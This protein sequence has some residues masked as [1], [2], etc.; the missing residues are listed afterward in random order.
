MDI[1]SSWS[2]PLG[3]QP[4]PFLLDPCVHEQ[5]ARGH[6][7]LPQ[8]RVIRGRTNPALRHE[9]V[10]RLYPEPEAVL[11]EHAVRGRVLRAAGEQ[12]CDGLVLALSSLGVCGDCVDRE[13]D[14]ALGLLAP[15]G[16]QRRVA[17]PALHQDAGPAAHASD[18]RGHGEAAPPQLEVL[19]DIDREEHPAQVEALDVYALAGDE[20]D[21][22]VEDLQLAVRAPHERKGDGHPPSR[23]DRVG[24]GIGMEPGRSMLRLAPHDLVVSLQR[25]PMVRDEGVVD[26]YLEGALRER[27]GRLLRKES[28]SPLQQGLQREAAEM[29]SHDALDRGVLVL[30]AYP[31]GRYLPGGC[32]G[33]YAGDVLRGV[34][35][36]EASAEL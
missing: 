11:L 15:P 12:V 30:L 3:R 28:V 34:L 13:D 31:A 25:L 29:V 32:Q 8:L 36:L 17:L 6:I 21:D 23:D 7:H 22:L 9:P 4:P 20:A 33:E 14:H 2:S 5:E 26:G 16:I 27:T 19:D 1:T 35:P 18:N 24:G 10:A